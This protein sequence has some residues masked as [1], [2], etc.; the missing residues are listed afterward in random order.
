M[1]YTLKS[2]TERKN[3]LGY[4][5]SP[6]TALI[7]EKVGFSGVMFGPLAS[8]HSIISFEKDGILLMGCTSVGYIWNDSNLFIPINKI[9]N[10]SFKK[11]YFINGR[12][13]FNA[14]KLTISDTSGNESSFLV[15]DSGLGKSWIKDNVANAEKV[16]A[17]YPSM[18]ERFNMSKEASAPDNLDQI[19][20]LK[21]LLD[22]GAITEEEFNAKK[23]QLLNL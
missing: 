3:E 8:K 9:G 7:A 20:K 21:D 5:P 10:L 17:S 16:S 13:V 12:L 19:A 23:K 1:A 14:H 18:K 6:N 11:S 15:Y 22:S 2:I 4:D